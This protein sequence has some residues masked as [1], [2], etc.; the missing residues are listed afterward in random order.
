M[1]MFM[2]WTWFYIDEAVNHS[3]GTEDNLSGLLRIFAIMKK[4]LIGDSV[5]KVI[6]QLKKLM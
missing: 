5:T 2:P 6:K 1:V 3:A 4:N